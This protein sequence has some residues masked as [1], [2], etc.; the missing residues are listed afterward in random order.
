[1][2]YVMELS[3]NVLKHANVTEWE[4]NITSSAVDFGCSSY[5][6]YVEMEYNKHINRNHCILVIQ[7]Q[8]KKEDVE[9]MSKFIRVIRRMKHVYIE[10]IYH[11]DIC[12]KLIYA[13]TFY[14]TNMDK[15]KVQIYQQ[16]LKEK[17][18]T[19][20]ELIF[21]QEVLTGEKKRALTL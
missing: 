8:E 2:V 1:M 9:N 16:F 13:S 21:L 5:Y 14:V 6:T 3:F 11:E 17:N 20:Q 12:C 4:G 19:E 15:D 18:Y 7:F 10:C